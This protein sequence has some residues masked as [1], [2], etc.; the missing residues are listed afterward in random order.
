[1]NTQSYQCKRLADGLANDQLKQIG[2][3][4][5]RF[6]NGTPQGMA[7]MLPTG[8]SAGEVDWIPVQLGA[9]PKHRCWG[10]NGCLARPTLTPSLHLEGHW[11]GYLTN[12]ELKSC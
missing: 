11:H 2:D 3:Y 5:W 7:I 9:T 10:W 1:M 4:T 6:L 8:G 12:G